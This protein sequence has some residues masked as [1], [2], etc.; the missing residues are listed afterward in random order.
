MTHI[1]EGRFPVHLSLFFLLNCHLFELFVMN[2]LSLVSIVVITIQYS[3][4]VG[5]LYY[6]TFIVKW[7]GVF[8]YWAIGTL[9]LICLGF[10]LV[11][12]FTDCLWDILIVSVV[13][14]LFRLF[15]N[16]IF[17]QV[18]CSI[19]LL[20]IRPCLFFIYSCFLYTCFILEINNYC[21]IITKES[22]LFKWHY[23]NLQLL[24]IWL[25][26][27]IPLRDIGCVIGTLKRYWDFHKILFFTL[28]FSGIQIFILFLTEIFV[29][30]NNHF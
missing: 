12:C 6:T 19:Y 1:T 7:R 22:K 15:N 25:T 9:L 20:Y 8:W 24:F 16:D 23:K 14:V 2:S 30:F 18:S 13:F 29:C 11:R 27:H 4:D 10:L 5:K 17:P 3:Y 26:S 21:I 28:N